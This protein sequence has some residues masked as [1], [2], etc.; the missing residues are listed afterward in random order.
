MWELNH[1]MTLM[2]VTL[3]V[4]FQ[5]LATEG[6]SYQKTSGKVNSIWLGSGNHIRDIPQGAWSFNCLVIIVWLMQLSD[7]PEDVL[8]QIKQ[9]L[10]MDKTED[11]K[12]FLFSGSYLLPRS[13][14]FSWKSISNWNWQKQVRLVM[15]DKDH[16][17]DSV[18]LSIFVRFGFIEMRKTTV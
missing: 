13:L 15:C 6:S 12:T 7:S 2:C 11:T 1:M 14:N 9:A 10:F 18:Y 4:F 8:I 17:V 3:G 5:W 16:S